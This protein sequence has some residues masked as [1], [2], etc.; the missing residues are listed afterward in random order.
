MGRLQLYFRRMRKLLLRRSRTRAEAEDQIQDAFLKRQEYYLKGGEVRKPENF[1]VRTVLR[2]A[3]NAARDQHREL[4]SDKR[5]E[6]LTSILHSN[7]AP[8]EVLAELIGF[9]VGNQT[10]PVRSDPRHRCKSRGAPEN[11]ASVRRQS[12]DSFVTKAQWENF[13]SC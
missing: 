9:P 10:E 2:L 1:L 4:Y 3:A 11:P 8:D 12:P 7:P 6:E 13:K 5:V